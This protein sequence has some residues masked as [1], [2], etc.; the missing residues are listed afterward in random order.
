MAIGG[1]RVFAC[2]AREV[3]QG[4][5]TSSVQIQALTADLSL[6]CWS[7]LH[8]GVVG[9]AIATLP[10]A[11]VLLPVLLARHVQG[12]LLFRCPQQ[13]LRYVWLVLRP[14]HRARRLT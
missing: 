13:H 11:L 8:R 7:T 12:L 2:E 3:F 14:F 6:Q 9:A 4:T 10:A 5:S 1:L